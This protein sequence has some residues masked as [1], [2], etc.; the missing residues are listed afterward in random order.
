MSNEE[1]L[2]NGTGEMSTPVNRNLQILEYFNDVA[3]LDDDTF[4]KK[5]LLALMR[6]PDEG[7]N[8]LEQLFLNTIC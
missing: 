8:C 3:E 2:K 7:W 1:R 5:F 6:L 4:K